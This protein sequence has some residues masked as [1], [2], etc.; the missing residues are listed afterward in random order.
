MLNVWQMLHLPLPLYVPNT[1]TTCPFSKLYF[2]PARSQRH[3]AVNE[4]RTTHETGEIGIELQA[5]NK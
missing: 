3:L 4:T 1:E 5:A 2:C